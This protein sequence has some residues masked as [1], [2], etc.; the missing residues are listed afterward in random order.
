RIRAVLRRAGEGAD[1]VTDRIKV[2]KVQITFSTGRILRGQKELTL[3]YYEAE[4]LKLLL[5]S[6][7]KVVD[8]KEILK[9]VWGLENEPMNRSVDN[10]VVSLRRK[11]EEDPTEP[12]HLLTV[13]GL[14][15][16]LVP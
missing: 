10:H 2:G 15:Y 9:E 13:H 5:K 14:G 8:R 7:G 6:E 12:R 11:I 1:G 16:K 4:I 3:G